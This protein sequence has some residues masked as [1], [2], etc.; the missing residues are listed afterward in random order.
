MLLKLKSHQ[1]K[2]ELQDSLNKLISSVNK[3]KIIETELAMIT[4]SSSK[5]TIWL[6]TLNS[7]FK[8]LKI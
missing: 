7:D 8:K 2:L 3:M 4:L 5:P 6:K 1:K